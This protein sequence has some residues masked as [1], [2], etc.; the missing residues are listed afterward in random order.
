MLNKFEKVTSGSI[1]SLRDREVIPE[2]MCD[3]AQFFITDQLFLELCINVRS[4]TTAQTVS[5]ARK[6]PV[7]LY[8]CSLTRRN[9]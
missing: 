2:Q 8:E 7:D 5:L 3:I 6:S 4:A 9:H 1:D